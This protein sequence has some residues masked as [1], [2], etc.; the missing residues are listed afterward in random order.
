MD[1]HMMH[2]SGVIFDVILGI[3]ELTYEL[4]HFRKLMGNFQNIE[5]NRKLIANHPCLWF[6]E[7]QFSNLSFD[8]V[9]DCSKGC[10]IMMLMLRS[11]GDVKN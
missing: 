11:L 4:D 3:K 1:K 6:W 2:L 8:D 7:R 5:V 10:I 9:I